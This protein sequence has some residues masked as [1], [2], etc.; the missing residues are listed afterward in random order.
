MNFLDTITNERIQLDLKY[1]ERCGGLWLRPYGTDGVYCAACSAYFAERPKAKDAPSRK[2]RRR[3]ARKVVEE[4]EMC[5]LPV[6]N[7]EG[8]AVEVLV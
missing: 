1:C 2:R 6:L 4:G 5:S 3:K 8:V 7:L